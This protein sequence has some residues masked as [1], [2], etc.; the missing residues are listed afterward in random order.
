MFDDDE[1]KYTLESFEDGKKLVLTIE[2]TSALSNHDFIV[3]LEAYLSDMIRATGQVEN[4]DNK[5]RH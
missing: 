1:V 2:S 3:T 5:T 4:P